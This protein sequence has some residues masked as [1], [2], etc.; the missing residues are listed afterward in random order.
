MREL[1]TQRSLL[2]GALATLQRSYGALSIKGRLL[3][4]AGI[5]FLPCVGLIAYV[6]ASMAQSADASIR[7]GLVY[8]AQTISGAVDAELRRHVALA[9]VLAKSPDLSADDLTAFEAEA[10][11]VGLVSGDAWIIVADANGRLLLNTLAVPGTPLGTRTAE[12]QRSQDRAFQSGRPSVSDVFTGPNSGEWVATVDVPV[13]K[14]GQ[15]FRCLSI[16]MPASNYTRL[17]AQQELPA[18]W[19]VGIIDGSGRYVSRIPKNATTTGQPASAGWR[20]N[21]K[22]AGI[23]EFPSIEGDRVINANA[24]P[25]LS[26]WTVGVGI[27]QGVFAQAISSTVKTATIAAITICALA[28]LLAAGIGRSIARPLGSIAVGSS[29]PGEAAPSDPPEVRALN[30]RLAAAETAQAESA[31]IIQDNFQLLA[32]AR[33]ESSRAAEQL[34]LAAKYGRL[35]T[36]IWHGKSGTSQW[37]DE[38]EELYGLPP[39]TFPGTYE[40]WLALVHPEDRADADHANKQALI[41]GELNSEWRIALPDGAIRWIEAR[42]RILRGEGGDDLTMIGVN[43]DVTAAKEADRKRE[44][45]VHELAHRVKNSLAVV[46]SLAHQ[47]LPRHDA[48]VRDFTSRLHALAT[49]HTSLAETDWQGADLAALITSQVAPFASAPGQLTASGPSILVPVELTTQLALVIHE[50]ACNASK[51]GALTTPNGRIDVTWSL[52]PDAL[53]V[54]WQES[55]GPPTTEPPVVGFGS[56]LLTRTVRHLQRTFAET[57]LTCQFELPWLDTRSDGSVGAISE[58]K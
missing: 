38:I 19:L 23:T 47:L 28:L 10:R 25:Q 12:G 37:S 41:T 30:A 11:R 33:D 15:P 27:K 32:K 20:A 13:F 22:A 53:H 50:M 46:Q 56:R 45:L 5:L 57:G 17:L 36:F 54:R 43:I 44:L 55:G 51:Y 58:A 1:E 35:G 7:R 9:E 16:S 40:D 18:D 26:D 39:G 52:G 24:H 29:T 48:K 6:I 31:R 42:A 2:G 49:V 3:L 34:K 14:D 4:L 8:A 21:A